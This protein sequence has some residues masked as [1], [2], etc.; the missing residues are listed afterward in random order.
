MFK[1]Q[2]I[3]ISSIVLGSV[4]A[5]LFFLSF[6][7]SYLINNR[8]PAIIEEK[9]DTPY[10][11]GYQDLSVNLL[12]GGLELNDVEVSPKDS[13]T[14][15][16]SIAVTGKVKQI[17]VIGVNFYKLFAKKELAALKITVIEPKVNLY[18]HQKKEKLDT[19]KSIAGQSIDVNSFAIEDGIFNYFSEDGKEKL[20]QVQHI[21]INFDGIKFN[22][23]TLE[24]KIPF[25]F[26][27]FQIQIDSMRFKVNEEQ[28]MVSSRVKLSD[29]EFILNDYRLK[30]IR[31][32]TKGYFPNSS[33]NDILDIESPKLVLKNTD[34]GFN[35]DDQFYFKSDLIQ[36]S[37]PVI[38]IVSAGKSSPKKEI[39]LPANDTELINIKEFKVE[40]AKIKIW[41]SDA[42]RPKF[43]IQNANGNISDIRMNELTRMDQIPIDYRTFKIKLDSMYYEPNNV[44]YIR[45]SNLD[46]TTKNFV[47]KN[48]KMKP[49]IS[50]NQ[51]THQK[52]ESNILLDIEAPILRLSNNQWGFKSDQFYFKTNSVRLDEV[53]VK[54]LDQK[55]EKQLAKNVAQ[56]TKNFLIN[57]HLQVDTIQIKK[58][59]FLAKEKFDYQNVELS[60]LGLNN[61]Y[62]QHLLVRQFAL[63]NPQFTI[64]GQPNRVAQN[65]SKKQNSFN[66]IIKIEKSIVRNGNLK[67]IPYGNSSPN[68]WLNSFQIAFDKIHIDPK[69][70]KESIPFIYESVDLKSKGIQFD[71]DKVYQLKT[72]DFQFKNGDF[73][74]NSF[75]LNPKISRQ[76]F[77]R[78]LKIETDLYTIRID[79]I[80]GKQLKWGIENDQSF[81][82]NAA[83]IKA[84]QLYANIYRNKAPA[85]NLS[86]KSMFS[87]K[88]RNLKFGLGI[89]QFEL[90]NSQ[91]EYEEEGPKSNAAGKLTF[92]SINAKIN[93]VNSGYKKTKLPDLNV[94]WKSKFMGGDFYANWSFNPMN[95]KENF[96]I[97]GQIKN[98]KAKNMDAFLKP[99]LMVSAEGDL[100]DVRFNFDG[101]NYLAGGDFMIQYQN[102]KLN[103]YKDNGDKKKLLSS[104][105]NLL[106]NK[107]NKGKVKEATVKNVERDQ[108][109]SFFNFFL[110]CILDGLKQTLLII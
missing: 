105:G 10:S 59:R 1:N 42:S 23:Y 86:R 29:E 2:W 37:S 75:R 35:T 77:V 16:D 38:N 89:K 104:V 22:E 90:V 36:F 66:D 74:V 6:F 62:G 14:I 91:L 57:F 25:K 40:D 63:N 68:L 8:L 79:K 7:I 53:E 31:G 93:N 4:L 96:K 41:H 65:K 102:L 34:W 28:Y 51:F 106:V 94:D 107:N 101:D 18:A 71:M 84:N 69:T 103:L 70:I 24:K 110:A 60:I 61:I 20:A 108:Q 47:L 49:L 13:L 45:A 109:K 80:T 83:S 85:D 12:K 43:Y 99:H 98:L 19:A 87:E 33:P 58:S 73:Q 82:V 44:Q 9:N 64:F 48:F 97:K 26:D 5:V 52:T 11:L 46:F 39:H 21:D 67:V 3:K 56:E 95:R 50:S 100:D 55:N 17:S 76:S 32:K 27:R 15:K 78:P 92:S 81:Y 72:S 54:I 30:P 88:L